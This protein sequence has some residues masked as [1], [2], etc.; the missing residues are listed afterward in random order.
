MSEANKEAGDQAHKEIN[1]LFHNFLASAKTL[2]EHTRIFVNKHYDDTPIQQAYSEKIKHEFAQDE[3]CKFIQDLRNYMLHQ[4]LPHNQM[5]LSFDSNNPDF[6]ST[7]S[8]E[9]KKLL[10]WQKWSASSKVFLQA[11]EENIKFSS[12]VSPYGNKII[13]LHEWLHKKLYKHHSNDLKQLKEL[14]NEFQRAQQKT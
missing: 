1:R 3:L 11:Q 8:L 6:E 14:Q 4:G 10:A 5:S 2:I 7:I 9:T 13:S 12:I